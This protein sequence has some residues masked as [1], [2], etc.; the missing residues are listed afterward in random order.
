[1]DDDARRALLTSPDTPL[2]KF[3]AAAARATA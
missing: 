1:M 3:R 2:R